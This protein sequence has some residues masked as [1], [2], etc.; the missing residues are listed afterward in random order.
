MSFIRS[1]WL[2]GRITHDSSYSAVQEYCQQVMAGWY[3]HVTWDKICGVF[4]TY[5]KPSDGLENTNWE[6]WKPVQSSKTGTWPP[7]PKAT[8]SD[9]SSKASGTRQTE[10]EC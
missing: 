5:H 9:G 6:S 10:L 1:I 7:S 3:C 2:T 4:Q 8:E